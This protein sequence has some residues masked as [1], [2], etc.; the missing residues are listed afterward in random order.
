M[1]LSFFG[2]NVNG[3][4]KFILLFNRDEYFNRETLPLGFYCEDEEYK[5]K[6][7]FPLDII[8]NGTF[9]CINKENGNFCILLNNTRED[10]PYDP[11]LT[12]KRGSIPI[13][14]CKLDNN[15]YDQFFKSLE[16]KKNEYNGYNII[17][18]N[19]IIGSLF[20]YS[21]NTQ[22]V[23]P[24]KLQQGEII[25]ISNYSINYKTEKIEYGKKSLSQII[26]CED[27]DSIKYSL[28]DL[29]QDQKKFCDLEILKNIFHFEFN[30]IDYEVKKALLSSIYITDNINNFYFKFGTRHT[31]CLIMDNMNIL[32]IYEYFDEFE[33]ING[34]YTVKKRDK[35]KIKNLKYYL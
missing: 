34:V 1:C 8:S 31:I 12:L 26:K 7:L 19:M 28:F 9:L 15:D 17:C 18:G 32:N 33:E 24:I 27:I 16:E 20:Y 14:F 5:D 21:N 4:I 10:K 13:E 35:N 2:V 11:K 30:K 22:E 23:C 3:K 6:L 25:G 29:M